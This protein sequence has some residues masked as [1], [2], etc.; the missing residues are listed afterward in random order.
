MLDR[1][2]QLAG[3]PPLYR[4][5][6]IIENGFGVATATPAFEYRAFAAG[7]ARLQSRQQHPLSTIRTVRP[8]N[9]SNVG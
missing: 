1:G 5:H 4:R 8:L 7:R 3:Q 6:G 2:F 9:C